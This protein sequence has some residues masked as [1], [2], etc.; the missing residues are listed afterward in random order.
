M[1]QFIEPNMKSDLVAPRVLD[2]LQSLRTG[3]LEGFDVSAAGSGFN[4]NIGSGKVIINGT[5]IYDDAPRNNSTIVSSAVSSPAGANTHVIVY[6][7]YS[8]QD[9]YPPASMTISAAAITGDPPASPTLP[10]DSV[11]FADIFIK[12]DETN[13]GSALI[14]KAPFI[15]SRGNDDGDVLIERLVNSNYNAICF[16]GGSI[17]YSAGELSWTSDIFFYAPTV[18][19]KEKFFSAPLAIGQAAVSSP[20]TGVTDDCL[21]YTV[22][23]RTSPG[24]SSVTLKVLD[25]TDPNSTVF[26]EFNNRDTREQIVIVAVIVGGNLNLRPGIG[27]GLPAPDPDGLKVLRNDPDGNHYWSHVQ[28][29][30]IQAILSI[31]SFGAGDPVELGTQ[32]VGTLALS[33]TVINDGGDGP[34][35]ALLTNNDGNLEEKEVQGDFVGSSGS[36]VSDETYQKSAT[37]GNGSVVFTLTAADDATPDEAQATKWWYRYTYWGFNA[38]DPGT[39][40]ET[41]VRTT[42]TGQPGGI[43]KALL[44]GRGA[45]MSATPGSSKYFFFAYPEWKGDVTQIVDNNTGFV[46][47]DAFEKVGTAVAVDTETPDAV[48]EETYNVYRS[49]Q[50]QSGNVNITVS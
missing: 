40:D 24:T 29:D 22:L 3:L 36:F 2:W 7:T 34:T 42:I 25:L 23:D 41:F 6:G 18:T 9:T 50:L 44:S 26:N 13:L 19:H 38:T 21:I 28:E 27:N 39:Y 30:M 8:Y 43:Q 46:V 11:K 47:T 45:T 1:T 33:A 32:L 48:V 37:G 49:N 14:V 5:T 16:G 20:L 17:L 15:P 10:A 12:K 31:S 4:I 35:L